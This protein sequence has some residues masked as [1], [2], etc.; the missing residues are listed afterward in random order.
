MRAAIGG[1]RCAEC[2]DDGPR[3][4]ADYVPYAPAGVLVCAGCIEDA[5][6]ATDGP[7]RDSARLDGPMNRATNGYE[8]LLQHPALPPETM[9]LL[10]RAWDARR[11]EDWLLNG[12]WA[13]RLQRPGRTLGSRRDRRR[14]SA[15][16]STTANA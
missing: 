5:G 13:G 16:P 14:P 7:G 3:V 4:K 11:T 15:G 9:P 2:G 1:D 8:L 12:V 10:K 6:G